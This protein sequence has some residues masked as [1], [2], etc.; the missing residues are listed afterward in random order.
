MKKYSLTL[1]PFIV[2]STKVDVY[3]LCDNGESLFETFVNEIQHHGNLE[4]NLASA[5]GII[6]N[7]ANKYRLPNT[8]FKKLNNSKSKFNVYEA[9]S[10]SIRIYLIYQKCGNIIVTG[11]LKTKQKKDINKVIRIVKDYLDEQ[12]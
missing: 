1:S 3:E 2:D 9:K 8:K 6:E 5:I 12:Q 4:K 11:G 10:G 7:N